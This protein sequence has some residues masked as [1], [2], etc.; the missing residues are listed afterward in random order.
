MLITHEKCVRLTILG[1]G[2]SR[3][4]KSR[5]ADI[6][7]FL[8]PGFHMICGLFMVLYSDPSELLVLVYIGNI[9]PLNFRIV[10]LIPLFEGKHKKSPNIITDQCP[11]WSI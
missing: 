9:I 5:G 6:I 2:S 1:S 4:K 8:T 10:F 3:K 7:L 11:A